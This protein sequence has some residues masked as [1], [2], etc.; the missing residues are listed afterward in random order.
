MGESLAALTA[1]VSLR[2]VR[3]LMASERAIDDIGGVEPLLDQT[4]AK[5]V[6]NEIEF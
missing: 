6:V 3:L 1:F 2:P 5:S 4:R